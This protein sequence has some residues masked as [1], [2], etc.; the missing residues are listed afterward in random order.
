MLKQILFSFSLA[1]YYDTFILRYLLFN[2]RATIILAIT[3]MIWMIK[4]FEPATSKV[5]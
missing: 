5:I 4:I 2:H 3:L 1:I